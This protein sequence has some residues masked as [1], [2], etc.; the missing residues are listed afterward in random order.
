MLLKNSL[1]FTLK[2]P[3][4]NPTL[5]GEGYSQI[6]TLDKA[7]SYIHIKVSPTSLENHIWHNWK[8]FGEICSRGMCWQH[9]HLQPKMSE[10]QKYKW[11]HFWGGGRKHQCQQAKKCAEILTTY[12]NYFTWIGRFSLCTTLEYWYLDLTMSWVKRPAEVCFT[13]SLESSLK[14]TAGNTSF[15]S[16]CLLSAGTSTWNFPHCTAFGWLR[17]TVRLSHKDEAFSV[18]APRLLVCGLLPQRTFR[19]M[20]K[21]SLAEPQS[22]PGIA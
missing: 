17:H 16:N 5:Q 12:Q 19:V 15:P 18:C 21:N 10:A 8:S 9:L 1:R 6:K 3:E 14:I 7:R 20:E 13:H 2:P 4:L 22:E 11:L